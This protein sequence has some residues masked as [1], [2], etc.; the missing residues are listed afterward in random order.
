MGACRRMHEPLFRE[1]RRNDGIVRI[2][3]ARP[4]VHNAFNDALIAGLSRSLERLDSDPDVRLLQLAAEGASFSAGADLNWMEAMAGYN[5]AENIRDAE[6]MAGLMERLNSFSRPTIAVVQG[7]AIGG[8]VGLVACCDIALAAD[9]AIFALS[10]VRLGLI[11]AVIS[12]YVL[13][14]IGARA[15]RRYFLTGEK[16]SAEEACRLGLLHQVVAPGQL[17]AR[18]EALS[19]SLLT[20]GPMAQRA[21]KEL[22]FS[23][24]SNHRS[25]EL[26]R[27]T[28]ARI[29]QLRASHE[30]REGIRAFLDRS[31]PSWRDVRE[32]KPATASRG[33]KKG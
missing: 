33:N 6:A 13:D 24:D 32:E 22:I 3:L 12:P 15:A 10:E 30:G 31:T 23:V 21:A 2:T 11:P 25:S 9:T 1:E 19:N 28:A 16:F 18:A 8:G 27:A 5:E 4:A 7:A 26:K 29:A 17:E 20:G 14:A